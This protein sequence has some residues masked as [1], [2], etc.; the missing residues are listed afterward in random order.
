M[1]WTD[2]TVKKKIIPGQVVDWTKYQVLNTSLQN[3]LYE[4]HQ[5]EVLVRGEMLVCNDVSKMK[6]YNKKISKESYEEY[7][8]KINIREPAKDKWVYNILDGVSEQS[9]IIYQDDQCICIPSYTWTGKSDSSEVNKLHVLCFP[10][11]KSLR[12][13]RSLDATHIN[14]LTHMKAK[15]ID[16][17]KAKYNLDEPDFKMYFHYEPSTYHLHIHFVNVEHTEINSSVEYSHELD[18]VIFNLGLDSDYYKKVY[19]NTR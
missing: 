2:G 1:D 7:L 15:S 14:L 10:R 5:V 16:I 6:V 19:L 4:K 12:C 11:D 17:I 13:I 8:E 18:L 9:D 3:D